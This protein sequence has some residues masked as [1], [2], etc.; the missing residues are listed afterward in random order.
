MKSRLSKLDKQAATI[1]ACA[2][3]GM[4]SSLSFE[5]GDA[6][7]KADMIQVRDAM[8]GLLNTYPRNSLKWS[9]NRMRAWQ[10]IM[11][12]VEVN[13]HNLSTLCSLSSRAVVE[14]EE[15]LGPGNRKN[16]LNTMIPVLNRISDFYDQR[17]TVEFEE[18]VDLIT[19]HLYNEIGFMTRAELIDQTNKKKRK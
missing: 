13:H 3:S 9:Y 11:E 15:R 6:T 5:I 16:V 19:Q 4:I 18:R 2:Q 14:L 1:I 7:L 10:K 12:E 17:D 8:H